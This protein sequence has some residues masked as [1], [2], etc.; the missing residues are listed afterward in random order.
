MIIKNKNRKKN[1][2]LED[3]FLPLTNQ[4]QKKINNDI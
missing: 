3:H 4:V 1:V 2:I